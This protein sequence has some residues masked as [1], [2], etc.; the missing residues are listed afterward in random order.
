MKRIIPLLLALVG[1]VGTFTAGGDRACDRSA[2]VGFAGWP[3]AVSIREA[4]AEEP[5]A[6]AKT[7]AR[8]SFEKGMGYYQRDQFDKAIEHFDIG[9]RLIPQPVFLYN[10]AQAHR[11]SS[12][13]QK[14][15]EF[16]RRYL[17]ESPDAKNKAEVDERIAALE[18]QLAEQERARALEEAAKL[19]EEPPPAPLLVPLSEEELRVKRKDAPN[20][21]RTLAIALGVIGGAAVVGTAIGLGI[22]FGTAPKQP[23]TT[24]FGTVTP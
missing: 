12:R 24:I 23:T 15:L 19:S 9:Y 14:A 11:L 10:I 6:E 5:S 22:Y 18:K 3:L 17:V 1:A 2:G 7:L 20:R 16:Y 8:R 4:A 21:K 13:P